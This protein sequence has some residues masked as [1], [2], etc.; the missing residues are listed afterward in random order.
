V[1]RVQADGEALEGAVEAGAHGGRGDSQVL[2]DLRRAQVLEEMEDHHLPRDLGQAENRVRDLP[3]QL[4]AG[5]RDLGSGDGLSAGRDPLPPPPP[6]VVVDEAFRS[7]GDRLVS[8][9]HASSIEPVAAGSAAFL[10]ILSLTGSARR[11]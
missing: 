4:D 9:A 3:V 8:G 10:T 2:G 5:D 6:D 11:R 7:P 1:G